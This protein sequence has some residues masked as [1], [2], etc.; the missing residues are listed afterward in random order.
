MVFRSELGYHDNTGP[1]LNQACQTVW[2]DWLS[3]GANSADSMHKDE[4]LS[5]WPLLGDNL[6]IALSDGYS[7]WM[8]CSCKP[9]SHYR[10]VAYETLWRWWLYSIYT[11]CM[12]SE[13]TKAGRDVI[14]WH[15]NLFTLSICYSFHLSDAISV[16]RTLSVCVWE[17]HFSLFTHINS[18]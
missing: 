6:F 13:K 5:A 2:W 15:F 8:N 9:Y 12:L 10:S 14:A 11:V 1:K 7:Q 4:H 17:N 16:Q 3:D 18:T